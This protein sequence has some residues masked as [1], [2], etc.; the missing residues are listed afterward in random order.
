MRDDVS[1]MYKDAA[2]E[3]CVCLAVEEMR[4]VDEDALVAMEL[5][6]YAD[7]M[8]DG[9]KDAPDAK[10]RKIIECMLEAMVGVFHAGQF[11]RAE[12][13]LKVATDNVISAN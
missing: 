4:E 8:R 3:A 6:R 12:R 1:E 9:L 5:V 2:I 11:E 7:A 13:M 10:L